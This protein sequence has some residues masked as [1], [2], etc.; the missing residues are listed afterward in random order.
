MR[1][2]VL[3]FFLRRAKHR[4]TKLMPGR[5]D[6]RSH[7]PR[8]AGRYDEAPKARP[9]WHGTRSTH[10][11]GEKFPPSHHHF[12]LSPSRYRSFPWRPK[13]ESLA[14]PIPA[15]RGTRMLP[16]RLSLTLCALAENMSMMLAVTAAK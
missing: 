5:F 14:Q 6:L 2:S 8:R 9:R 10:F 12:W 11:A 15:I 1:A 4:P 3:L 16:I 7:A 13:R